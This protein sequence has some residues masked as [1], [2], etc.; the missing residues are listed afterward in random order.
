M[1]EFEKKISQKTN[2]QTLL[3]VQQDKRA[4][5]QFALGM[6]QWEDSSPKNSKFFLSIQKISN[7]F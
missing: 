7:Q 1:V 5:L 3:Q 6:D 4:T 2:D